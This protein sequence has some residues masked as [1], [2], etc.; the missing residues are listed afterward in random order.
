MKKV[1]FLSLLLSVLFTE[2]ECLFNVDD[3]CWSK[4]SKSGNFEW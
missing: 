1:V 2:I 3:D 4:H